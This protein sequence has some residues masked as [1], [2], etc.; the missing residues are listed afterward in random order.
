MSNCVTDLLHFESMDLMRVIKCNKCFIQGTDEIYSLYTA[1]RSMPNV[2]TALLLFSLPV[3]FLT[4]I[5][6]FIRL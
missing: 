1:I 2:F 3:A 4:Y 5:K 6:L